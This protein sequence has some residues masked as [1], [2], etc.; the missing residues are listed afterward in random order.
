MHSRQASGED[1]FREKDWRADRDPVSLDRRRYIEILGRQADIEASRFQAAGVTHA[2]T[3]AGV[4]E[5][6]ARR[7]IRL[8]S[9]AEV[10]P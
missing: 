5:V 3:S 4:K 9:Y 7:K 6:I 2:F 10:G 8:I 1:I